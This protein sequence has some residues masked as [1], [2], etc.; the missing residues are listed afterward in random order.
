MWDRLFTFAQRR[1]EAQRTARIAQIISAAP[2]GVEAKPVDEGVE[3]RGRK[4]RWRFL[5]DARLRDF[6]R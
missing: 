1:A 3:L 4:L 2:K 6:W 5:N